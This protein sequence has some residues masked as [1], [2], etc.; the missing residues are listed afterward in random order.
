MSKKSNIDIESDSSSDSDS[1][2][3]NVDLKDKIIT[4]KN[5]DK[6]QDVDR[7]DCESNAR[8]SL[9]FRLCC[10]GSVN[11]GKTTV[12]LN[13][14]LQ[15][16][17]KPIKFDEIH[18]IHG[19]VGSAEYNCINPTSIRHQIPHYTD[20]PSNKRILLVFDDI[21]FTKMNKSDLRKIVEITR[22]GSHLGISC[23][24][25]NQLFVR[26]PKSVRDNCNVFVLYRPIDLDS[27]NLIGR[28][29]G[30]TKNKINYM[31]DNLL[32]DFHDSLCVN[33]SKNAKFRYAKNLYSEIN[34]STIDFK[35]K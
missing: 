25:S 1:D 7:L 34:I 14:I 5:P 12:V 35:K 9:P 27:L 3:I 30:L 17:A 21:E 29:V 13:V 19:C 8:F 23:I 6:I 10:C 15:R 26:V 22:L 2:E 18:I 11:S 28:R 16:Q 32:P 24:F 33:Y 31:Y 4:I 20:F